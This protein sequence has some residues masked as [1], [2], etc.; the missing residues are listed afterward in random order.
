VDRGGGRYV[1]HQTTLLCNNFST[2][3]SYFLSNDFTLFS[4][5][6]AL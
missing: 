5:Y 6:I 1:W 2:R 4:H 3:Y